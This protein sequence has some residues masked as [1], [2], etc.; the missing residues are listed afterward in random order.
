MGLLVNAALA[1]AK[2]VAGIA[3]HAYALVADAAESTADVLSSVV[4]WGGLH[5]ASRDPDEDYP[6]GY[7]KAESLSAAVVALMLL[8]AGLAIAIQAVR[9]IRTPHHLPAPWTL[10]VLVGVVVVKWTLSRR[11]AAVGSDVGSSAVRADA[12]HHLSDAITSGAAFIGISLAVLAGPGWESADDWAALV[13]CAIIVYNG[14]RLLRPALADLMDRSADAEI[15]AAVRSAA[16]SVSGVRAVEKLAVRKVGMSFEV[17]I[18]VHADP[19]MNLEDA[20]ALG[21]LVK[22]TIRGR[23]PRVRGVLVHMEPYHPEAGVSAPI[24]PPA[25]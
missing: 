21:G 25:R 23:N 6:F 24:A 19:F 1:V 14:G 16:E 7:G 17:A 3:G 5:V 22:A 8:G 20:H 12:W 11:V 10:A 18:H 15:T 4:V 13:A 9:E 2:L